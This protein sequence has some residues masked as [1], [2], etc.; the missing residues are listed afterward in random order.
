MHLPLVYLHYVK[1]LPINTVIKVSMVTSAQCV[2]SPGGKYS[3]YLA[4]LAVISP[5]DEVVI[6]APYWVSYPEMVKLAGGI[7]KTVFAGLENGFKIT[8][9]QLREQSRRARLVIINS[10]SIPLVLFTLRRS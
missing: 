4:I 3:C 1:L 5:G 10:P 6:P 7:P 2:V 8:S 9:K